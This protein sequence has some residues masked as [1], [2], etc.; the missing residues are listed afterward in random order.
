MGSFGG[1]LIP[2]IFFI[3]FGGWWCLNSVIVHLRRKNKKK[4]TAPLNLQGKDNLVTGGSEYPAK[5]SYTDYKN[6]LILKRKSWIPAFFWPRA[7]LEPIIKVLLPVLGIFV[8]IFFSNRDDH[9]NVEVFHIHNEEGELN[10]PGKLYHI[11]LYSAFLMSG[12]VDLFT[13]CLRFP[14]QTS[15]IFFAL[16]F[17]TEGMLFYFH[18][19]GHSDFDTMVHLLIAYPIFACFLFTLLRL[20]WPQNIIINLCLGGSI[21]FQG[22][23]LVQIGYFL[24]GGFL[25]HD[26][27]VTHT[28]LM[29]ATACF[30]WHLLLIALFLLVFYST[31][32]T[33]LTCKGCLAKSRR[34]SSRRIGNFDLTEERTNLIRDDSDREMNLDIEMQQMK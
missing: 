1:H 11:T 24:F 33:I 30:S 32:N 4:K 12:C 15:T 29:F 26:R 31:M 34:K 17:L 6:N 22:T 20:Q 23:W 5:Y 21:L 25:D 27:T 9:I 18:T 19:L 28:Q 13:L 16:S 3:I 8:E 7:P 10:D 14:S 2:G